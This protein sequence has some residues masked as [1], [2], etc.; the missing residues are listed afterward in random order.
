MKFNVFVEICLRS[1]SLSDGL[2]EVFVGELQYKAVVKAVDHKPID[3]K[4]VSFASNDGARVL[5]FYNCDDEKAAA[6][7]LPSKPS[8]ALFAEP[9]QH[10]E[11]NLEKKCKHLHA[12]EDKYTTSI[13]LDSIKN[14]KP[15][16]FKVQLPLFVKGVRDVQ[17]LLTTGSL[18][19][20][21][22]YEIGKNSHFKRQI[23][24]FLFC[25]N[26]SNVVSSIFCFFFS[27]VL[28]GWGDTKHLIRKN[29][30]VVT[31]V[32]EFNVLNEFKP[33]KVIVELSQNGE[34]RVFTEANKSRP[35]LEFKDTQPIDQLST[36]S[37]TA[38][39]R[40][41]DFYYGCTA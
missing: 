12:W 13:K 33:I 37:F 24:A 17:I 6:S 3:V 36:L 16:G 7:L 8:H 25:S 14:S 40:D 35:L 26:I 29:G 11:E 9:I 23:S 41:L 38:Y 18:D 2:I 10:D 30:D 20:K 28:G 4:Y 5:F 32:N 27:A 15:D 34:L 22:G 1:Q 39:Y 31:K 21:D 19:P